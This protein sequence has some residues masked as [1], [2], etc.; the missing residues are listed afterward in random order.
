LGGSKWCYREGIWG[1]FEN[2]KEFA[3]QGQPTS[4]KHIQSKK[5]ICPLGLQV[6]EIH[7]CPNDYNLYHG[8]EFENLQACPVF[9]ALQYKIRHDDPRDVDGEVVKKKILAKVM[10]YFPII[11]RL[12]HL[13]KNKSHTK[14]MQWH[15]EDH[16]KDG[17]L[18]HPAHGI[19]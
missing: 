3:S 19:Q 15:K 5:V 12:K 9:K 11:P 10:W 18:R 16:L 7:A 1:A 2:C 17:M 6:Q 13:F 8:K 4:F 14:L